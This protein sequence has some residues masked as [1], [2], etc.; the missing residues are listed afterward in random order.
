MGD[1]DNGLMQ[2]LL[3]IEQL[4]LHITPDQGIQGAKGLITKH[5]LGVNGQ[6]SGQANSLLHAAA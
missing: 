3:Q 4:I 5:N 1:E 2:R 6:G